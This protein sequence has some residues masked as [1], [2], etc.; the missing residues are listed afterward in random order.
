MYSIQGYK[1]FQPY[2]L[3]LILDGKIQRPDTCYHSTNSGMD[4]FIISFKY[5]GI[6]YTGMV[7]PKMEKDAI[8]YFVKLE[9]ENQDNY[10]EIIAKPPGSQRPDWEFK[11]ADEQE[12]PETY[13][14]NLLLEIGE[15][16]EK[17]E[18]DSVPK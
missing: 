2:R 13:D 11:C 17:N 9:S 18:T 10:L 4:S 16:I 5:D 14:K 6:S 8:Y 1:T 12:P 3:I 15:A 7:A